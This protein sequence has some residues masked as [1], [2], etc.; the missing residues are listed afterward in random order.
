M[1]VSVNQFARTKL[2]RV[3]SSATRVVRTYGYVVFLFISFSLWRLQNRLAPP[4]LHSTYEDAKK[5]GQ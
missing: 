2:V 3:T 1:V 4:A 5:D